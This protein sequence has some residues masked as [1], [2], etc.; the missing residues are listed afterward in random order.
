MPSLVHLTYVTGPPLETQVRVNVGVGECRSD[1]RW[2]SI[3]TTPGMPAMTKFV[4][5]CKEVAW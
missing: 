1:V 3:S 2:K 4:F 5:I